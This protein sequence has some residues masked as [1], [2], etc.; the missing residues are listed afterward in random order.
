MNLTDRSPSLPAHTVLCVG[1]YGSASTWTYNLCRLLLLTRYPV[2]RLAACYSEQPLTDGLLPADP[3]A[4]VVRRWSAIVVKVHDGSEEAAQLIESG[5]V[6]TV[7]TVRD[8]RD[9]LTSVMQRFR[10][11]FTEAL[12]HLLQNVRF[13]DRILQRQPSLI[14][15]YEDGFMHRRETVA[16]LAEFLDLPLASDHVHRIYQELSRDRI[17][18]FTQR[19]SLADSGVGRNSAGNLYHTETHWHQGHFGDGK[20]GK[21]RQVLTWRQRRQIRTAAWR[22]ITRLGYAGYGW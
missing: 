15:R 9:G 7:I 3:G 13:V 19:L 2:D 5:R 16:R 18:T 22:E 12:D 10:W 8:P 17:E 21:W 4:P 6:R 20:I 1:V 11:S 14:L